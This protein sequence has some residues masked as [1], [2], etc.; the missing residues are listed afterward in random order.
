M[1]HQLMNNTVIP[2]QVGVRKLYSYII[3]NRAYERSQKQK[4]N[5]NMKGQGYVTWHDKTR[6][7]KIKWDE[8]VSERVGNK[9]A[10]KTKTW[11]TWLTW[12]KGEGRQD[13]EGWEGS[14]EKNDICDGS[15][16]GPGVDVIGA[17]VWASGLSKQ[18][19]GRNSRRKLSKY[20]HI[21]HDDDT[22]WGNISSHHHISMT[23]HF[24]DKIL[25]PLTDLNSKYW[26][27][28]K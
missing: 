3:Y 25:I 15:S 5:L 13:G 7:K 1:W 21:Q 18:E 20:A 2:S 17:S 14:D 24:H 9:L 12:E 28:P 26:I 23:W 6:E 8:W 27:P 22:G 4:T 19:A 10:R 11:L 16:H